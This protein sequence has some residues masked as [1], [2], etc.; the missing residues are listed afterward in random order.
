MS[1]MECHSNNK[2]SEFRKL[3]EKVQEY[4]NGISP[5]RRDI[6]WFVDTADLS[7]VSQR[8][9]DSVNGLEIFSSSTQPV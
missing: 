8:E 5:V 3:S 6:S 7:L 2:I 1:P 9:D 4:D